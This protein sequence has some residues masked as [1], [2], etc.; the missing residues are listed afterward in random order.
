MPVA[1]PEPKAAPNLGPKGLHKQEC[2]TVYHIKKG[3]MSEPDEL[4]F[5]HS[6]GPFADIMS[7][8]VLLSCTYF[9]YT[10][11]AK[12]VLFKLHIS[13]M[14]GSLVNTQIMKHL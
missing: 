3:F 11:G 6:A 13:S 4:R 7:P 2:R 1:K 10:R 9:W 5:V 14:N 12:Q 8:S